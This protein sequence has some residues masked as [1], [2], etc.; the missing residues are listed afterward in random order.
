MMVMVLV[1]IVAL[2]M[3]MITVMILV[4]VVVIEMKMVVAVM[5]MVTLTCQFC[6]H[7]SSDVNRL[8]QCLFHLYVSIS[9]SVNARHN[10]VFSVPVAPFV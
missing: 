10:M 8:S 6:L 3:I 5:M 7:S 9:M 2:M 1:M 4:M